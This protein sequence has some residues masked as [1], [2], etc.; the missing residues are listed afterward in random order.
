MVVGK[1]GD[2]FTSLRGAPYIHVKS[3]YAT[4]YCLN[5][6]PIRE[7]LS[8][9][10]R[11]RFAAGGCARAAAQCTV[12]AEYCGPLLRVLRAAGTADCARSS[13]G[14]RIRCAELRTIVTS[15]HEPIFV[16]ETVTTSHDSQTKLARDWAGALGLRSRL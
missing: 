13:C 1:R 3:G 11:L 15:I 16:L 2:A 10:G 6:C 7:L 8:S 9:C 14:L 5:Y 4:M 12:T